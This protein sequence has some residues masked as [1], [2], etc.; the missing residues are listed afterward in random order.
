MKCKKQIIQTF[1]YFIYRI[2]K[3]RKLTFVPALLI[4]C[5]SRHTIVCCAAKKASD[6]TVS[7]LTGRKKTAFHACIAPWPLLQSTPFLHYS[8]RPGRVCHTAN[9][10]KF[11]TAICKI[12][13]FKILFKFLR[14]FLLMPYRG[15]GGFDFFSHTLQK[16]L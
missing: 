3:R 16:L 1:V 8:C 9:L 2:F 5:K 10:I 15:Y 13:V 6:Y 12:W 14:F 4:C 11:T 7:I